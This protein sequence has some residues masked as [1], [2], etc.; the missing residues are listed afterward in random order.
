MKLETLLETHRPALYRIAIGMLKDH[1]DAEDAVQQASVAALKAS[2]SFRGSSSLK[3]WLHRIISNRCLNI[4]RKR[5]QLAWDYCINADPDH[6]EPKAWEPLSASDIRREVELN[7][8][9]LKIDEAMEGLSKNHQ[10]TARRS[11]LD[12]IALSTIAVEMG[13]P[14]GT[15]RSR[16]A[17]ARKHLQEKLKS[18]KLNTC[19]YRGL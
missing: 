13:V 10:Q 9:R 17:Y 1:S 5:K 14:A 11:M 2:G 16:L 18:E 6:E 12:G 8:L 7:E 4:I 19:R 15:V 3:T